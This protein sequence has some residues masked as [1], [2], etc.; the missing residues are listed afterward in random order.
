MLPSQPSAP[1]ELSRMGYFKDVDAGCSPMVNQPLNAD[2]CKITATDAFMFCLAVR[3]HNRAQISPLLGFANRWGVHPQGDAS[4]A[5]GY[6]FMPL[7]GRPLLNLY[8]M[9][10]SLSL[11]QHPLSSQSHNLLLVQNRAKAVLSPWSI[12]CSRVLQCVVARSLFF[13]SSKT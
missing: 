10:R 11:R 13:H 8:E 7:W 2:E 1:L 3:A 12:Q 9:E 6:H 5:L 4:L